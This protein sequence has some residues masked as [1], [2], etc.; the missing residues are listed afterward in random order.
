MSLD[1]ESAWCS[2]TYTLKG[3]TTEEYVRDPRFKAWGAVYNWFGEDHRI[4][5]PH[6]KLQS[7]F[8]RIDWSTTALLCQNT[9]FDGS[10]LSWHYGKVPCFYF[11]TLS[12]ARAVRGVDAGNSLFKLAEDMGLP[13]KGKALHSTDGIL[14]GDLPFD[15]ERELAEYCRHDVWLCEEVFKRL[16]PGYPTDELRLIDMTI[17]MFTDPKFRLD[18]EMLE[19][20]LAEDTAKRANLLS[21]LGVQEAELASADKFAELLVS[22]GVEPPKKVSKTTGK[23]AWAFA[24]NDAMFQ[25][26]IDSD[27]ENVALLCEARLSVKSTQA[28][29]RAQRFVDIAGRGL[30]P[31]P[32]SYWGAHT[33]RWAARRGE[34]INVQNMKRG[35]FLRKALLAPEGQVCVV[36]D[37][38]QIEPRVLAWFA[39]YEE[40][41]EIFRSGQDAY[42]TFGA[43]MF[44]IPGLNKKDHPELRQSSKAALLGCGYGLGWHSFA[45]QLLTGFLGAPPVLYDKN[46]IKQLGVGR[47]AIEDFLNN[48]EAVAKA[49]SI[50]RTCTDKEIIMHAVATKEI[51]T[52]YREA[53]KPVTK[54][55]KFLGNR[56]E[57]SLAGGESFEYKGLAFQQGEI[58]LPNRMSLKYPEL[59]ATLDDRGGDQWTYGP[60]EKKLYGGKLCENIVQ[61]VARIVMTDGML[62]IQKRYPVVLTVHDE[63]VMLVP[64]NEKE[65]A[66]AWSI[67]QM[68]LEP[69]Y[70]P[71]IPLAAE[72]GFH[73]RYG[74]A[75]K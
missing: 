64:E 25:T 57:D 24:K 74:E 29:T 45:S 16:R 73:V 5:V 8:D 9:A 37:L 72:G 43:Q 1:F 67:E 6:N 46:F 50:P 21:R 56:L 63:A 33:G 13:P 68:T 27:D 36:V 39:G 35:S 60:R 20:A 75:K 69:S 49:L 2:K 3:M 4:W 42:A 22:L 23:E 54:F 47:E 32:L 65:E 28:R 62:R 70:L 66:L 53:A 15:T 61:A 52:R 10:I 26:L 51:V 71:G 59:R 40:L 11:D 48:D 58:R 30:L 12:M 55:W 44:G 7:F 31:V 41:L 38:S 19:K 34:A 17:R 18:K 14:G